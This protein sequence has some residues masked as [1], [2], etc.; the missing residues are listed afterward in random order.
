MSGT[1]Q[2][3]E[4]A[5]SDSV[6]ALAGRPLRTRWHELVRGPFVHELFQKASKLDMHVI[7]RP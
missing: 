3:E 2:R 4:P 5:G 6:E 7:A 1:P